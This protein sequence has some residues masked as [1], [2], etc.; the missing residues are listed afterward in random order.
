MDRESSICSTMRRICFFF[1]STVLL[2]VSLHGVVGQKKETASRLSIIRK[3][4]LYYIVFLL[5]RTDSGKLQAAPLATGTAVIDSSR[6][7]G[8]SSAEICPGI[9]RMRPESRKKRNTVGRSSRMYFQ[10]YRVPR[11]ATRSAAG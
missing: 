8:T 3:F 4:L 9:S 7:F 10:Y 5:H 11:P 1:I 2:R 6:A